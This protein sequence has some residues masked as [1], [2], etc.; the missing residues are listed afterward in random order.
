MQQTNRKWLI[1]IAIAALAAGLLA[2]CGKVKGKDPAAVYRTGD[3]GK[4]QTVT[5][6]EL[7]AFI[8]VTLSLSPGAEYLQALPTFRHDMLKQLL[9]FRILSSRYDGPDRAALEKEARE[10]YEQFVEYLKLVTGSSNQAR[11]YMKEMNFTED[12]LLDYYTL[13]RLTVEYLRSQIGEEDLRSE[14]EQHVARN[15]NYYVSVATVSHILIGTEERSKEEALALAQEVRGKILAGADF[16]DMAREYSEDPGSKDNGGTYADA[17]VDLWVPEFR[18]AV[19]ELPLHEI[20]EPVE[21]AYGYHIIR[22]DDRKVPTFEEVKDEIESA[23]LFDRFNEFL[24]NE[25]DK[26][27]VSIAYTVPAEG[28]GGGDGASGDGPEGSDSGG[29]AADSGNANG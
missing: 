1:L 24:E 17:D 20:S 11:Q 2:G 8:G 10:N 4:E 29:G 19:L 3:Q 14:F 6:R 13:T 26:L 12:D 25:L 5:E 23:L 16:A 9:A 15:P 28:E 22:V 21:T 27:I 7:D 18:Q